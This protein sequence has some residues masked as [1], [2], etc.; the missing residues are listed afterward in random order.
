MNNKMN[1][2]EALEALIDTNLL[3]IKFFLKETAK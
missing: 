1:V 2:I 3:L